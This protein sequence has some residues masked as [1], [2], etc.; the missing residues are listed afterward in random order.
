MFSRMARD[1]TTNKHG[2][3][4]KGAYLDT[5][6]CLPIKT[7]GNCKG[8]KKHLMMKITSNDENKWAKLCLY[9]T[10]FPVIEQPLVHYIDT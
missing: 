4:A 8:M 3:H 10:G 5:L 6:H 1:R 9:R 7:K 2:M